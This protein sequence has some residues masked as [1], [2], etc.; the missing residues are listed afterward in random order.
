MNF[1]FTD[2]D[3]SIVGTFAACIAAV[4][5]AIGWWFHVRRLTRADR[6]DSGISESISFV[7]KELRHELGRLSAENVELRARVAAGDARWEAL[8]KAVER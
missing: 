7:L 1:A 3:S 4:A 8:Q 5:T 2:A 6:V